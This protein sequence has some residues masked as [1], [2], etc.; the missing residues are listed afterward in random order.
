M[1]LTYFRFFSHH[2]PINFQSREREREKFLSNKKVLMKMVQRVWRK[3]LAKFFAGW[4]IKNEMLYIF[5][6]SMFFGLGSSGT[7]FLFG[8][9]S[10]L[11]RWELWFALLFSPLKMEN[12]RT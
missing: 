10:Y 6:V 12:K 3:K 11:G 5:C 2:K 8:V 1:K 9:I 4:I 7:E